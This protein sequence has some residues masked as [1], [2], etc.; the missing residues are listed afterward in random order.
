MP[1]EKQRG[2]FTPFYQADNSS[3][4]AHGGT[5]LGLAI[6]RQLVTLFHGAIDVFSEEG[7]GSTFTFT[8]CFQVP[9]EQP[10]PALP[11]SSWQVLLISNLDASMRVVG[12][13][14]TTCKIPYKSTTNQ[15]EAAGVL[16]GEAGKQ[17]NCVILDLFSHLEMHTELE[18]CRQL[19]EQKYLI[20]VGTLHQRPQLLKEFPTATFLPKPVNLRKLVEALNGSSAQPKQKLEKVT[21]PSR[22]H[23]G[24]S[25]VLIVE[26]I[27]VPC[28]F[29]YL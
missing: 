17:I 26:G 22:M 10:T 11:L 23:F 21:S 9:P 19:L 25:P 6:C 1:K 3:T 28:L 20:L 16:Q 12:S 13:H 4:R 27:Q 2:L 5:G 24:A 15:A 8:A 18:S 29:H 7:K 14:L